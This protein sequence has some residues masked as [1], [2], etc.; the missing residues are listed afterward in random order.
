MYRE[1]WND[2]SHIWR[3]KVYRVCLLGMMCLALAALAL[4]AGLAPVAYASG[5]G[6]NVSDPAV[7][8]VDIAKPAVVRIVTLVV[9]QL[10]VTI[11]GKNVTFPLTPQQ[12]L[13][14]YP[15]QLSGTGAFISAHGDLL[16]ADHVINPVQDDKQSMD[17]FLDQSAAPDIATYIN[18]KGQANQQVTADQVTQELVAGQLKSAPIYQKAQSQV[19]L[20]T[21]FSGHIS[22]TSFQ[23]LPTSQF[24][25][26]DQIKESSPTSNLDTAIIHVSGMDNMPMLQLGD[27]STVQE[28]DQL[29][30]IG[31][32][33]NGD[34]NAAPNDFLTSSINLINVS[35]IKTTPSGAPLI[36]VG[37]NVEHGDSGGP[38]LDSNG[39]VVGIVSFGLAEN[40]STTFLQ[41]SSSAKQ[42]IQQAGIDTTPSA[43]QKAWSVAFTDYAATVP[44]HWHQSEREFQ[45]LSTQ[46]PLFKAVT[47]FLQYATQQAQSEK[48]T[49]EAATPTT[50]GTTNPSTSGASGLNPV[51]LLIGGLV[52]LVIIVFG[53]SIAVS[54]A[55]RRKAAVAAAS[56]FGYNAPSAASYPG[57]PGQSYGSLPANAPG[58]NPLQPGQSYGNL[59][60]NASGGNSL[61]PGQS[62]GTLPANAPGGN[63]LQP[64]QFPPQTPSYPGQP[65][66]PQQARPQMPSPA[67]QQAFR[68]QAPSPAPQ[69]AFR[70][71]PPAGGMAAFGAPSTPGAMPVTPQ[72]SDS[73]IVARSGSSVSQWRIWPCGHTNRFDASFCGTCGES[74][75]P[76]PIVRRVEQ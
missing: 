53:G 19:F 61:Q 40:G 13:N 33:G 47:P 45:Q 28:Q 1:K 72:P 26:V 65:A 24:A 5:P 31:F 71:Q 68:P 35:S 58:G 37:G 27:S 52:V 7:R 64:G 76:A 10:T 48:Q 23:Q 16:T 70:P 32:P 20:S 17:Q 55:R 4:T 6:G 66:Y 22:A 25:N 15:L 36:Q 34:V 12:G 43:F 9:S 67:P 2:R 11:N 18:Q 50:S 73:T 59:P 51:Y 42:L 60:A 29:T 46:Y 41:A 3:H 56:P 39:H 62:Y 8:A 49:Q 30:I 54:R 21:D 57:A 44:G 75:P 14:G 63:P 69:P 74:A 38:A